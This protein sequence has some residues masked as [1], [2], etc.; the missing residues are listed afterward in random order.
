MPLQELPDD[1]PADVDYDWYIRETEEILKDIGA[2]RRIPVL[3]PLVTK[4]IEALI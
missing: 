3:G 1:F 2:I 4:R